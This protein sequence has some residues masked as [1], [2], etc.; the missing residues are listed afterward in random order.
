MSTVTHFATATEEGHGLVFLKTD[1]GETHA[2]EFGAHHEEAQKHDHHDK[3]HQEH[4]KHAQHHSHGHEHHHEHHHEEH[5]HLWSPITSAPHALQSPG[6]W[7]PLATPMP[8]HL[9]QNKVK[10][11]AHKHH[12]AAAFVS[13]V[14]GHL[15][16]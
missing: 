4:S 14:I 15:Q 5:Y 6:E 16:S 3:T 1:D 13:G 11:D 12:D 9:L 10:V 2:F 7:K 8:L